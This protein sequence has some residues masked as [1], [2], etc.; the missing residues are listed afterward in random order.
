M[1]IGR[2]FKARLSESLIGISEMHVRRP[3]RHACWIIDGS[4]AETLSMAMA[5]PCVHLHWTARRTAAC[6]VNYW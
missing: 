3:K 6:D 5:A 2:L 1:H 4:S